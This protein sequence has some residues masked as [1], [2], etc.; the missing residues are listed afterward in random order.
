MVG[1]SLD[2]SRYLLQQV[3][4]YGAN[5]IV[6]LAYDHHMQSHLAIKQLNIKNLTDAER[7]I[8]LN[9]A[10]HHQYVS[11]HPNIITLDSVMEG[12]NCLFL[13]MELCTEG[14]L[15]EYILA[16]HNPPNHLHMRNLFLQIL[17]SVEY[18]HAKGLYHRDLKP[19]NI[20]MFD[21]GNTVKLTDFG[22]STTESW[23]FDLGCGSGFYMS[24]ECCNPSTDPKVPS[25]Y[26]P[27]L[28][29]IWS[30]GIILI[31][32]MCGQNPWKQ[33]YL[34]DEAFDTYLSD[35][36]YLKKTLNL[37]DSFHQLLKSILHINPAMRP[38]ISAIRAQI[39]KITQFTT[40]PESS[41]NS[42]IIES[43]PDLVI[44]HTNGE[45]GLL[46]SPHSILDYTTESTPQFDKDDLYLTYYQ[47]SWNVSAPSTRK[48]SY[49]QGV[50]E[51]EL[52]Y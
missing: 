48:N 32:L 11:G 18:C 9:E 2:D 31:N 24:P 40:L 15:F 33:A 51:E 44:N 29:D 20:M 3:I 6:Y 22:L 37:T 19:E 13:A 34:G 47:D 28:N 42:S 49:I 7:R 21:G 41:D 43:I 12:G 46:S 35:S 39:T 26:S 52:N 45:P 30:L 4:G 27:Q 14:D 10:L 50:I 38:S 25:G 16:R 8:Q 17:D 1:C 36:N 23:S 5:G